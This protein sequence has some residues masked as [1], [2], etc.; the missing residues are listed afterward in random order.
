LTLPVSLRLL[1]HL[2][3][4]LLTGYLDALVQKS[5]AEIRAPRSGPSWS[6]AG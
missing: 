4:R 2:V 6:A 3:R 5:L 1:L